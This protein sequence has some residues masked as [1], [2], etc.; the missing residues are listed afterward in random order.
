M[1]QWILNSSFV[2]CFLYLLPKTHVQIIPCCY[3]TLL[4]GLVELLK[5][6]L[7]LFQKPITVIYLS[8]K[9]SCPVACRR[10]CILEKALFQGCL[11]L[12]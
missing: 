7:L 11:S 10:L 6:T 2:N 1:F 4:S 12:R 5:D 8:M 3:V 9:I